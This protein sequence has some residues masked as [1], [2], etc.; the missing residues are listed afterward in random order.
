VIAGDIMTIIALYAAQALVGVLFLVAGYAKL[1]GM[2]F[3]VGPFVM[4]GLGKSALIIAGSVEMLAG[5]FLLFPRAG[6]IG[7]VMAAVLTVATAGMIAGHSV[8]ARVGMPASLEFHRAVA[9][10]VE[11]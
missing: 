4:I 2:D 9:S 1:A 5:A 8:T 3:M 7:A 6:A 11:I 10:T